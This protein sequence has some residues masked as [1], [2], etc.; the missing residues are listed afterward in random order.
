MQKQR[1]LATNIRSKELEN[2]KEFQGGII[3]NLTN[4]TSQ[5]L[6]F[7]GLYWKISYWS[8]G[9]PIKLEILE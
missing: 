4:R 6:L 2:R 8:H 5:I 1:F 7:N 3:V 9:I